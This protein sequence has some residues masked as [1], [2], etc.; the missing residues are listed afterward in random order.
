MEEETMLLMLWVGKKIDG[1]TREV[2][3]GF[4]WKLL[5]ICVGM[6]RGSFMC[7]I[8]VYYKYKIIIKVELTIYLENVKSTTEWY[9]FS[10]IILE[11]QVELFT[12]PQPTRAVLA[13]RMI[14]QLEIVYDYG[15]CSIHPTLDYGTKIITQK[16]RVVW[17]IYHMPCSLTSIIIIAGQRLSPLALATSS[18]LISIKIS[19]N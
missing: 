17:N 4:A 8:Y 10:R 5:Q 3:E 14:N 15:S 2:T 13:W 19:D 11:F 1:S 6:W 9:L 16:T 12:R 18:S 7:Q